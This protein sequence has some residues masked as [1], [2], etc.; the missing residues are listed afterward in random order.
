[1]NLI[2]QITQK[3]IEYLHNNIEDAQFLI[4]R[5]EAREEL[6]FLLAEQEGLDII[7]AIDK[8]LNSYNG[9]TIAICFKPSFP[10]FVIC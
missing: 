1:M 5:P 10:N 2:E 8:Q 7:T 6:N 3:E 9:L 4:M